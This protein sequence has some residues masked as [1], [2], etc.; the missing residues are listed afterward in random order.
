MPG[1]AWFEKPKIAGKNLAIIAGYFVPETSG[2][3]TLTTYSFPGGGAYVDRVSEGVYDIKLGSESGFRRRYK[4]LVSCV[5]SV[6]YASAVGVTVEL[7]PDD[8]G[9]TYSV[10]HAT[11]PKV[12]LRI[13][14]NVDPGEYGTQTGDVCHCDP[15][16]D[17][18]VTAAD[19]ILTEAQC[20]AICQ[21]IHDKYTAH[22]ASV[23]SA[24]GVGGSHLSADSTNTITATKPASTTAQCITM[25]TEFVD[26]AADGSTC[27]LDHCAD[28]TV[29]AAA[30]AND[31]SYVFSHDPPADL[32]ECIVVANEAK[33]WLN[34]HVQQSMKHVASGQVY[35]SASMRVDVI[36]VLEVM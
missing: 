12:R 16:S 11:D 7:V 36:M 23:A 32:A 3:S 27:F 2:T 13:V 31:A 28:S 26:A 19:A 10:E 15:Q 21:D 29:H 5:A 24:G 35:E 14:K 34:Q 30:D 4:S 6:S 18:I 9:T 20:V 1:S 25:M 22:I 17:E 33:D 8:G